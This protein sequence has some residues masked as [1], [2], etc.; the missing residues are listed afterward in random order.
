MWCEM[1]NKLSPGGIPPV[2]L[3]RWQV[4]EVTTQGGSR[5]RHLL[6]HDVANDEGRISSAIVNFQLESM[7]AT[8]ASGGR[9]RL[10]GLPGHSRKAQPLW[11][12][13]CRD[14]GVVAQHNVTNDYMDPE[15]MSTRQF[16]ALNHSAI[17]GGP[18]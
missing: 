14:G 9:Y 16:V 18:R 5:S 2:T 10:A 1:P 4:I 13:W 6:G 3:R 8:T 15:D 7:T 11:E 12:Q 17:S